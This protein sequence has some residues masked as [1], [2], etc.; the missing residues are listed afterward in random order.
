M[1]SVQS[2][3]RRHA[4]THLQ[5]GNEAAYEG[6]GDEESEEAPVCTRNMT[7]YTPYRAVNIPWSH[8]MIP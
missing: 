7:V 3:M 8:C 6:E 4:H 1:F 2:N 5:A